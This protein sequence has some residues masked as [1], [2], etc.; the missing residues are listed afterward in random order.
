[1]NNEDSSKLSL[2]NEEAVAIKREIDKYTKH[3]EAERINL[4][5]AKERY[6]KQFE[7]LTNLQNERKPG[8]VR[9]IENGIV[10]KAEFHKIEKLKN[11]VRIRNIS[12]E[13]N[14][15]VEENKILKFTVDEMRKDKISMISMLENLISINEKTKKEFEEKFFENKHNK[16]DENGLIS[17]INVS[18]N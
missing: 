8:G 16:E 11:E 5:V 13:I 7:I 14:S 10:K 12:D 18:I 2:G 15:I 17:I 3:I 4:K 1:M 9:N 6:E